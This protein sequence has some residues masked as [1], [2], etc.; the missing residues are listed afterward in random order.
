MLELN[1]S[2]N[3]NNKL[4][5]KV[6][7]TLRLSNRFEINNS[8][9]ITL[10]K[11]EIGYG[12]IIGKKSFKLKDINDWV[13]YIDTGYNAEKCKNILKKMYKNKNINWNEQI[14]YFYLIEK[15]KEVNNG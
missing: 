8:I 6:F 10:N 7:T 14:I 2:Y 11:K 4:D 13:A 5:C 12:K 3:W 15:I 1:F 9:K